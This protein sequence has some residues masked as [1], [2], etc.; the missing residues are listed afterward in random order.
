MGFQIDPNRRS[1][2]TPSGKEP[3]SQPPAPGADRL[4]PPAAPTGGGGKREEAVGP[5]KGG[6]S[7]RSADLRTYRELAEA[8]ARSG[9]LS[10]AAASLEAAAARAGS[11][12]A[13]FYREAAELRERGGEYGQALL[14]YRAS[15][16][17]SAASEGNDLPALERHL[18][19][20]SMSLAGDESPSHLPLRSEPRPE[21]RLAG[22]GGGSIVGASDGQR[23]GASG[24]SVPGGIQMLAAVAGIDESLLRGEDA[25]ARLLSAIQ[26]V[27]PIRS[28]K[29]E[30]NPLRRA[31]IE[32]IRN[33]EALL[34]YMRKK[35]LLPE[36][37]NRDT[38]QKLI[39]P[40]AGDKRTLQRTARLL[41]FFGVK[42]RHSETK[43]GDITIE[44]RLSESSKFEPRRRLMRQMGIDMGEHGLRELTVH[45]RDDEFP[46]FLDGESLRRLVLGGSK[47]QSRSHLE[48]L[49]LS[50]RAVALYLALSSAS[51]GVRAVLVSSVPPERLLEMSD[52]L[53][54]FA[55]YLDYRKGGPIFPGFERAWQDFLGGHGV[56][57]E[58]L[59][60]N[61]LTLERGR[62]AALYA[63]LT[64]APREVQEYFTASPDRLRQAY[65]ALSASYSPRPP[66]SDAGMGRQNL[67]RLLRQLTVTPGGLS[68]NLDSRFKDHLLPGPRQE[69]PQKGTSYIQLEAQDLA[70]LAKPGDA[71]L[72]TYSPV[73]VLEFLCQ[74]YR[75]NPGAWDRNTIDALMT[76]LPGSPVLMDIIGDIDPGPEVLARY[77]TY[78]RQLIGQ[79]NQKWN[80]NRTRT[81]QALFYLLSLLRREGSLGADEARTL[82]AGALRRMESEDEAEF[83]AGIAGLLSE[84][85]LPALAGIS[86]DR[87]DPLLWALAGSVP[88]REFSFEGRRLALDIAARRM[89]RMRGAVMQQRFTPLRKML[90]I[91]RLLDDLR[92]GR[93]DAATLR[94]ELASMLGD[95][96]SAQITPDTPKSQRQSMVW[97]DIEG[98]KNRLLET[99]E[100]PGAAAGPPQTAREVA[101]ALHPELG[102]T[103][104]AY[105][106]AY[107]GSPEVDALAFDVNFVRKHDFGATGARKHSWVATRLENRSELGTYLSGSLSGIDYELARLEVSQSHGTMAGR[108][109]TLMPTMLVGLRSTPSALRSDRAQEFVALAARLGRE[110]LVLSA[111]N[112]ELMQWCDGALRRLLPPQRHER[113]HSLLVRS[114]PSAAA[115]AVTPSEFF[116]LGQAYLE[117]RNAKRTEARTGNLPEQAGG[118]QLQSTNASDGQGPSRGAFSS[119][120]RTEFS[121]PYLTRLEEIRRK[122]E[123]TGEE[124]FRRELEQYGMSLRR[125]LAMRRFTLHQPEP[126]EYLEQ[127]LR[128]QLLFER[129]C[130]LKVQLA[131]L[132]YAL[133]LPAFVVEADAEPAL[134]EIL[135]RSIDEGAGDWRQTLQRIA[136]LRKH[137]VRAWIEEALNRGTLALVDE[138]QGDRGEQTATTQR[139]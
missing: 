14:D 18:K 138:T 119:G 98:L 12:A 132:H 52:T 78:C 53:A 16:E 115:A 95:V 81:S 35:G 54:V 42:L 131:E 10:D 110:V 74:L 139:N 87:T 31:L 71:D 7:R 130:D 47:R 4:G 41:A 50:P 34:Q 103:L 122:A 36:G 80:V 73:E 91:Y 29:L 83:A 65:E 25:V 77:I 8:Y 28:G 69:H 66:S 72:R 134:R 46:T 26:E 27:A 99:R 123:E 136:R 107:H 57:P 79:R 94:S 45:L 40:F 113:V 114:K 118:P 5:A 20:L 76:D 32:H 67:G 82:L 61:L 101:A 62:A 60:V 6:P 3:S 86:Q 129:M 75:H 63:G 109:S 70:R 21:E 30:D 105:C 85:L 93:G 15:I 48:S 100:R 1:T 38:G 127:N 51:E 37:F 55:R 44:L 111:L 2:Q 22:P 56:A 88:T 120:Q 126:Y 13:A 9:S 106:Y 112:P 33:Y 84:E 64:M 96:Q 49:L 125:R 108:E 89:D 17:L 90:T 23:P 116:F 135:S 128:E 92:S 19:Y 102:V 58:D 133:G 24:L 11:D 104:L 59:L 97:T 68:L 121:F 43:N 124:D 39:F 117:S 137:H